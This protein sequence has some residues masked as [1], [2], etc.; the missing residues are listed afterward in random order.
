MISI[1]CIDLSD[2]GSRKTKMLFSVQSPKS[3][4]NEYTTSM[5]DHLVLLQCY[6]LKHRRHTVISTS[7]MLDSSKNKQLDRSIKTA[8]LKQINFYSRT[9]GFTSLFVKVL[10]QMLARSP[11]LRIRKQMTGHSVS[12]TKRATDNTFSSVL[13]ILV[14]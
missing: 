3:R 14:A 6:S 12:V 11:L 8:L 13:P 2:G 9:Y 1:Q 7:F 10:S 5:R 4:L